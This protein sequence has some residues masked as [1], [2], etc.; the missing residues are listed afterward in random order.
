MRTCSKSGIKIHETYE[1][2]TN[3]EID[4]VDFY[5]KLKKQNKST[6]IRITQTN[7][8]YSCDP[9]DGIDPFTNNECEKF[10]AIKYDTNIYNNIELNVE[11]YSKEGLYK[12]FGI[13]NHTL[14]E[15][16]MREI[17][18][19]VLKTHPD[20]S[21]NDPKYF[22]FFSKAYQRLYNIYEFQNKNKKN[23]NDTEY[24]YDND[25]ENNHEY[26][27]NVFEKD[28]LGLKNPDKFNEWFNKQFDNYKIEDSLD[29]GYGDWL[30]SDENIMIV[31]NINENNMKSEIEKY[32]KQVRTIVPYSG[33]FEC[34]SPSFG[35]S[36]LLEYKKNNYSNSTFNNGLNYSDLKESYIE[37]VI[38]VT[39]EDFDKIPKFQNVEEYKDYRNEYSIKPL[40]KKESMQYL[41]EL[42]KKDDEE[43]TALAFY[44]AKQL[45]KSNQKQDVFWSSLKN[46]MNE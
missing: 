38:P 28:D 25:T 4:P 17:K 22:I 14:T 32:K 31:S 23:I 19:N 1:N 18:R 46:I 45:E 24:I 33:L 5:N 43:S 20:K 21:Q 41:Y 8:E 3:N 37:T 30:K 26:L 35:A 10:T 11:K 44:Y 12:L 2:N 16:N 9:F 29:N 40:N 15:E 6:G 34:T 36:S 27:K 42:N 7:N 39:E 13:T